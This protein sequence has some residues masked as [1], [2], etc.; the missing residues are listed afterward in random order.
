MK[1]D[2]EKWKDELTP[3][4]E[5]RIWSKMRKTLREGETRRTSWRPRWWLSTATVTAAAALVAV[6]IWHADLLEPDKA[7]KGYRPGKTVGH[8]DIEAGA[9]EEGDAAAGRVVTPEKPSGA[10]GTAAETAEE[11]VPE[12]PGPAPGSDDELPATIGKRPSVKL[13]E[14]R[15]SDEETGALESAELAGTEAPRTEPTKPEG[16]EA[17]KPAGT[18]A[19]AME[20]GPVKESAERQATD[21]K[22]QPDVPDRGVMAKVPE[23]LRPHKD[24]TAGEVS[25]V[26][27]ARLG[28]QEMA[29]EGELEEGE[30]PAAEAKEDRRIEDVGEIRGRVADA[31]GNPVAYAVITLSGTRYGALTDETGAFR[32]KNVPVGVYDISVAAEGFDELTVSRVTVKKDRVNDLSALALKSKEGGVVRTEPYMQGRVYFGPG[33]K[34]PATSDLKLKGERA[35]EI[36]SLVEGFELERDAFAPSYPSLTGGSRPVNDQLADDMYFTH[37]GANPFIDADEDALSTFALDVDT[38]SYTICRR[39]IREGYLPPPDAPRVEEFVN[40]FTKDFPPPRREDFQIHIDGMPSPFAHVRNGDYWLLRIGVRGRVIDDRDREP[41]QIVLVID[42]S[43][44]M[45]MGNRLPLLKESMR[46]LLD[47]LR[48]DDEIG[49]VEFGSRARVVLPLT[50]LYEE[51]DIYRAIDSLHPNGSTNAEHGLKLGYQMMREG[52]RRGRLHRI[53]FCS[54]G[55]AN[56]GNTG[57][58]SILDNVRRHSDD[59]GLTTIGFG[60]GNYNDILMEQLADAADGQYA[61]VDNMSEAKRVL[62]EN[63]TG[64]LQTIAKDVKAQIEFDPKYV[65]KYRLLGYENRDVRDEDFRDDRIDAG[66]IGSGHEVTILYEVKLKPRATRNRIATVHLRYERPESGRVIEIDEPVDGRDFEPDVSRAP[67]DLVV[68]ACVAEFAEILRGSYWAKDGSLEDVMDLLRDAD[69]RMTSRPELDELIDL[70]RRAIDLEEDEGP[71][72]RRYPEETP[73]GY[74]EDE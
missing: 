3:D 37:Y 68:D 32:V 11:Q 73:R 10:E 55:V 28:A 59:I 43:G 21:D 8:V 40:F 4:E 30:R 23:S 26:E 46:I 19:E 27:A 18:E 29:R 71:P 64:T 50:P 35:G 9:G 67:A 47:E 33:Q 70:V 42:T 49:I 62:R 58:E 74:R 24:E 12:S 41:A 72:R 6:A 25:G 52:A 7:L 22:A 48:R 51:G 54:D 20:P 31:N 63:L 14:S 44:S 36:K 57:W 45:G 5:R 13:D 39:Y 66:E 34:K 17:E 2:L 1:R 53:I 65:Q 69:D 15:A 16:T 56:V 38:G 60:M 61:Y